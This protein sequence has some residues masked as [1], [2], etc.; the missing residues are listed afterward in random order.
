MKYKI[1]HKIIEEYYDGGEMRF[2]DDLY[3]LNYLDDF[4]VM[5]KRDSSS[6]LTYGNRFCELIALEDR[7]A[8]RRYFFDEISSPLILRTDVGTA[9]INKTLVAS[10][11][12]AA[13]SF[14]CSEKSG[15]IADVALK[16]ARGSIC[17]PSQYA[18]SE[19]RISNVKRLNDELFTVLNN[20]KMFL[21]KPYIA[22]NSAPKVTVEN[23]KNVVRGIS[24]LSGCGVRL[25]A[26]SELICDKRFDANIFK[27][28]ILS[29][30]MLAR[31]IAKDRS[32][33]LELTSC[34]EGI[35][36]R[37]TFCTDEQKRALSYPEILLFCEFADRNNMLFEASSKDGVIYVRL[38]PTR[39][40]WSLIGLKAPVLFDWNS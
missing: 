12:V 19:Q 24:M 9:I 22:L 2:V 28:F 37:V 27:G 33:S 5:A 3:L 25:F 11:L 20:Y 35:S 36:V 10:T 40:D 32:A 31:R 7:A 14:V 8:F 23:F 38:C 13:V 39:K 17:F 16:R 21:E 4:S 1:N 29:M 15:E 30:F 6:R 18:P 26:Y 34:G